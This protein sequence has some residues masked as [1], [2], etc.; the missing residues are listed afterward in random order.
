VIEML[1]KGDLPEQGFIKQEQIQL[2]PFLKTRSGALF[3]AD[4]AE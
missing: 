4:P 3:D 1:A 2:D